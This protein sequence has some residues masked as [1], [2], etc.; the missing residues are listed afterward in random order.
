MKS[1]YIIFILFIFIVFMLSIAFSPKFSASRN[2]RTKTTQANLKYLLT[3]L[4]SHSYTKEFL[5]I[6]SET[7]ML[8]ENKN[9]SKKDDIFY[10]AWGNHIKYIRT[11]KY[12]IVSSAGS[13]QIFNT[14]DDII[15]KANQ[16]LK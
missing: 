4:D 14:K 5:Q 3:Q 11:D 7:N 12:M 16:P 13:D 8:P 9:S 1:F 10:D 2:A 6:L 15:E